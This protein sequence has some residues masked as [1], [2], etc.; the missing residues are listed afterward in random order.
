[1]ACS[2]TSQ[3]LLNLELSHSLQPKKPFSP[4]F[5]S[6]TTNKPRL[7]PKP[8]SFTRIEIFKSPSLLFSSR[9][10]RSQVK[11]QQ[12][13][14]LL[15]FGFFF[16]FFFKSWGFWFVFLGCCSGRLFFRGRR[17]VTGTWLSLPRALFL[18][19]GDFTVRYLI[20]FSFLCFYFT[21]PFNG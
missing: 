19:F 10:P 14:C 7:S 13:W 11:Y 6:F 18:V 20:Y 1:M 15:N 8:F 5:C 16:F 4:S 9:K 2:A 21:F 12:L 3:P 17:R